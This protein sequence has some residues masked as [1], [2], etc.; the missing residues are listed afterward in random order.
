MLSQNKAHRNQGDNRLSDGGRTYGYFG[1]DG[2]Y[3]GVR[4]CKY[5]LILNYLNAVPVAQS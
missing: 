1:N 3:Y 2:V 5:F 4:N